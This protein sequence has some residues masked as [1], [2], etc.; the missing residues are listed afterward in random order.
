MDNPNVH[1]ELQLID[2]AERVT[3][4]RQGNLE[5][6]RARPPIGFAM[7]ALPPQPQSSRRSDK[8]S[9][10]LPGVGRDLVCPTD[11]HPT[12]HH[13]L[14]SLTIH[15]RIYPGQFSNFVPAASRPSKN[16]I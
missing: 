9:P 4:K 15:S 14:L 10:Y 1:A 2:H 3:A 11:Y 6:T 5:H 7:S 8:W 16:C 13:Y 12:A